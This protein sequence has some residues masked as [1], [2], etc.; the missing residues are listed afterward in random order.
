[1]TKRQRSMTTKAAGAAGAAA[2]WMV[3][4]PIVSMVL[5]GAAHKAAA[6]LIR[7]TPKPSTARER[8][9]ETPFRV[10]PRR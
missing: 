3:G 9:I 4:G 8:P 6:L 7:K 5:A 10:D 1:M 2:G